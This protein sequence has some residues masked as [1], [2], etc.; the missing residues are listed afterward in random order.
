MEIG[1]KIL[2]G[3]GYRCG[4]GCVRCLGTI[5]EPSAWQIIGKK[6]VCRQYCFFADYEVLWVAP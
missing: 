3:R 4:Y 2:S 5:V 1:I 6:E